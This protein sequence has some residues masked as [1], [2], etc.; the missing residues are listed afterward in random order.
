MKFKIQY[1]IIILKILLKQK[2]LVFNEGRIFIFKSFI[3]DL[4]VIETKII[5]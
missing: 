2:N 3:K 1:I 5:N 4:L